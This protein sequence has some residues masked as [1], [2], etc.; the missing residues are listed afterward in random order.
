M[1]VLLINPPKSRPD[2]VEFVTDTVTP[3]MGLAYLAAVLEQ[4][5]HKV[6]VIDAP[7]VSADFSRI[8]SAVKSL[9]PGLVGITATT[10]YIFDALK[11]ARIAKQVYPDAFVV[12]GGPHPTLMPVETL[13]AESNVDAVCIGEGERTIVEIAEK[14][15]SCNTVN[16][17]E[18]DGIAYRIN[19]RPVVNRRRPL[20]KDLDSLPF[21]A[22]H[23][24]PMNC[25]KAFGAR[26]PLGTIITSRGCPF[27]CAFC[28]TP[29]IWGRVFRARSPKN[30]VDEIEDFVSKYRSRHIEFIDDIF[31]LNK[32]RVVEIC[33]EIKSRGLDILW[34]CS[35]R[36]D[37]ITN[38]LMKLMK[39][40][41]CYIIYFGVESGVQRI[42]NRLAKG[43]S[44]EQVK[45]AF[46]WAKEVGIQTVASFIL[47]TPGETLEEMKKTLQFAKSLDPDFAQFSI[48]TP[49]PGTQIYEEIRKQ[50][51][52]LDGDW[53]NYTGTRPVI[54]GGRVNGDLLSLL[55]HKAYA[56][57]YLRPRMVVKYLV[58]GHIMKIVKCIHAYTVNKLRIFLR[59]GL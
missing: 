24:L 7:A 31:T 4:A 9:K 40:A 28:A 21:P 57:F 55:L 32:R 22:R 53:A 54:K 23:L 3:P 52:E 48:L 33:R 35:S 26:G 49:Y 34:G 29:R 20:I 18:I 47:G 38:E 45:R 51:I 27:G 19:G 39:S 59:G 30:I 16:L 25:Y 46:K 11:V 43:V 36:V 13:Q 15:E 44:L 2:D 41:G 8:R 14:L 58:K 6:E 42:L 10:P 1:R 12:L 37:T 56:E 50:G 5:G 17:S